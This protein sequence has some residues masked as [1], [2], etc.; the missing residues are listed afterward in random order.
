VKTPTTSVAVLPTTPFDL[1]SLLRERLN[2][3]TR[4]NPRFSLR[5]LARQLRMDHS[6]LSQI[7]RDKRPLSARNV[8]S[9][10]KWLGL[11][12][13]SIRACIHRRGKKQTNGRAE[14]VKTYNLDLDT[15]Q[16][17]SLWHHYAILELTHIQGFKADSN[18]IAKTLGIPV[19]DVNIALQRLLRLGL[20]QMSARDRWSDTSGDAEF[21][22]AALTETASVQM[23]QEAH[24]LAI[25][26][27]NRTPAE[28][29]VQRHTF[30]A[31]NSRQISRL[32]ELVEGFVA[33]LRSLSLE[34][35]AKD[36]VFQ[37]EISF[38]P[39]TTIN[40]SK[41]SSRG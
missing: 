25:E 29:R 22:S 13:E 32:K 5:S 26:A 1:R 30:V 9:V 8:Q 6:T 23:S 33:E 39:V 14:D 21:R 3:A 2:S 38:L 18:W 11:N 12:E 16:L 34:S 19:S 36:D 10:G 24:Q 40:H 35:E 20:L 27:I 41:G 15:F 37:L 4:R 7:L 31:F 17:L 28:R